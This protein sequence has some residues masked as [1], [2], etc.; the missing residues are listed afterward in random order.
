M[1]ITLEGIEGC[2][3]ST[4]AVLLKNYLQQQGREVVLTKEP[5]GSELGLD[6]RRI[7]LSMDNRDISEEAEL[8]LY[9]ADRAQHVFELVNPSI[10]RGK[11]VISDRFADSTIVYQGYGRGL[12]IKM[13][14][15]L[16]MMA[17][18]NVLPDTTI[19]LD[20]P[21]EAG[22]ER[23]QTRNMERNLTMSEGRFE[24]ES[25][26][27]HRRIRKGYLAW[28]ALN[29]SRFMIIDATQDLDSIHRDIIQNLK[30]Q[31]YI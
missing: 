6:L 15:R 16:N 1:F 5:G 7:L 12:D 18:G 27:F 24:A 25:I 8:F 17:A 3:K 4:Q 29:K 2:G 9:L 26:E 14:D 13:L 21:A 20:L 30:N 22:L 19:L 28:A 11:T 31:N 10:A 23:A